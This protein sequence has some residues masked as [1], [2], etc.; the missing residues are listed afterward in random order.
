M[1]RVIEAFAQFFD[2]AGD[3]LIDGFLKF[4][5][6]GTN[7]TDKDTFADVSETIDNTNPVQLDGEGRCPNVFGPG[8]YRVTSFAD[9]VITPGTPGQQIQQFDPV[10]G[11]FG[12]GPL[13]DWNA[14]SIYNETDEVKGSDNL[15]YRSLINNNQGN[16]PTTDA[17]NWEE[18]EFVYFY[19][20]NR[21]YEINDKVRI[22]D[23]RTFVSAVAS[24]LNNEPSVS[25]TQWKPLGSVVWSPVQTYSINDDVFGSDGLLYRSLV[26]S[27]LNNDPVSSPTQWEVPFVTLA[28][29]TAI[30][31]YF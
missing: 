28:L 11:T 17:V 14:G 6:S 10:G 21:T 19:N 27:N 18:I 22:A 5:V 12:T 15:Y 8:S 30:G 31:L 2:G 26:N 16:D 3:P 24:N 4:T 7:N 29:A 23:G 20:A 25:P 1:P 13:D 9:S